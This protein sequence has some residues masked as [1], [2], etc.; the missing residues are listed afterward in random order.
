MICAIILKFSNKIFDIIKN[1]TI[2]QKNE[3]IISI[4]RQ[5]H[6]SYFGDK[7][8]IFSEIA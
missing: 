6:N 5:K 2:L 3:Q 8:L 7:A 1:I 4:H